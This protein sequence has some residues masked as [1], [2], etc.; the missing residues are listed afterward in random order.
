MKSASKYIILIFLTFLFLW[1]LGY[2][3]NKFDLRW[4]TEKIQKIIIDFFLIIIYVN[5]L[6]IITRRG[7]Y[8]KYSKSMIQMFNFHPRKINSF[9]E[10]MEMDHDIEEISPILNSHPQSGTIGNLLEIQRQ[11]VLNYESNV[12]RLKSI[13]AYCVVVSKNDFGKTIVGIIISIVVG[14]F[15]TWLRGESIKLSLTNPDIFN[16]IDTIIYIT[17]LLLIGL[18]FLINYILKQNKKINLLIE[19]IQNA[20]DE[21]EEKK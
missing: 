1:A 9:W 21:I 11:F 8:R 15:I 3:G 4:I 14:L 6:V 18:G 5:Y 13:K 16:G 12:K 20:I 19:I 7:K 10:W 17:L 2:L